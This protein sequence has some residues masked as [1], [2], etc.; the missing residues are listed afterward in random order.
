MFVRIMHGV[1]QFPAKRR[2]PHGGGI[3]GDAG[4]D[5]R[6]VP[7]GHH[8]GRHQRQPDFQHRRQEA[9]L[10]LEDDRFSVPSFVS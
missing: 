7:G 9:D 2:R 1:K 5:Y 6:G 10:Q 8:D 4:P 3:R